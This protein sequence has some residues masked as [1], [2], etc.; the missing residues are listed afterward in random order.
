MDMNVQNLAIFRTTVRVVCP[1]R[2]AEVLGADAGTT[3][4]RFE[5]SSLDR[6]QWQRFRHGGLAA[7]R[8]RFGR[9]MGHD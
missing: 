4:Y 5:N 2:Y 7:T 8:T 6:R 3:P 1:H 9:A